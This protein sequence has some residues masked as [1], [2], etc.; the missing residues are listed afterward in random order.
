MKVEIKT[1]K[2]VEIIKV[3]VKAGVRYWE[4]CLVNGLDYNEEPSP[5]FSKIP[6]KEN[7][8]WCPII[9]VDNGIVLNWTKGTKLQ[10]HFKV[11]DECGFSLLD[12]D[13]N[14]VYSRDEYVPSFLSID[15]S[16][17]GDYILLTIDGDGKILNWEPSLIEEFLEDLED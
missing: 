2:E 14:T 12:A 10:T 5:D 9:D 1:K 3:V 15:E 11:C 8:T 7:D 4:D 16:G 6:C 13:G 17:Y